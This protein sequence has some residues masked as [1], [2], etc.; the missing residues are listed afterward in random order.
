MQ[1][2]SL[3]FD[4]DGTLVDTAPDLFAA[5]NHSL[6]RA[7]RETIDL[8]HVR[9]MVGQG[10]R[11]LLEKGMTATG[12]MPEPARFEELMAD[13]LDFY[14]DH[15]SDAST[16]YEGVIKALGAFQEAGA[17][18][19]VCTNKPIRFA[20][21]LL[22]DL[23]MSRYFKAMTGGDSFAVRKPDAAHITGTL[24]LMGRKA[25]G[26]I[27][28]GDSITDINAAH[29]AGIPCIAVSFGYTEI[30]VRDLGPDHIIDHFDE[31]VPLVKS[32]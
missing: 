25:G 28:I 27:M 24:D 9:H 29:N 4:L 31:L 19:G 7:G 2:L 21:K 20:E 22:G 32:L 23:G 13:F 10:A 18:M 1:N 16:P 14:A 11:A 26:A 5:L 6:R 8:N 12:G 3:I 15:V 30:H 17:V